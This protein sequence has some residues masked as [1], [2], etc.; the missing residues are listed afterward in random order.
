[1]KKVS[2]LVGALVLVGSQMVVAGD[3]YIGLGFGSSKYDTGVSNITGS[4]TLDEKDSAVKIFYGF[5]VASQIAVEVHYADL[6]EASLKGN[7]GD[8]FDIDS[9]SFSFIANDA[10]IVSEATSFG[11]SGVFKLF[12]EASVNPYFKAGIHRWDVDAQVS[13]T[14]SA[15]ASVSDDGFDAL[16]GIGADIKVSDSFFIR[17]EYE[18]YT[19]GDDDAAVATLSANIVF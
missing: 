7:N 16:F 14:S 12:D 17:A 10:A 2:A 3:S 6:G 4:A 5:N 18:S 15:T 13:S 19:I 11:V 1:M 9:S 8:T